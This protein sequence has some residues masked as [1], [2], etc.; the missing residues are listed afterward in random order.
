MINN[1]GLQ[2]SILN[3]FIS[4]IR[5]AEIQKD[6]MRFRRHMERIG[7]IFAYEISKHFNY[8]SREV[9]TSLGVSEVSVLKEQPVIATILR[10]GLPLHQGILNFFDKAQ[11]A[12]VS[13]YRRHH[14]SGKF[15]IQIEYTSSPN[16]DD[17]VLILSDPMLA[18]GSSMLL[19]YKQLLE[20]G[21][22]KHTHI[23]TVIASVQGL[24]YLNKHI[25]REDITVWVAAVDDELTAQS[26]IVPGLGDAGDLAYGSKLNN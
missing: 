5:D 26:Y 20:S 3:E 4:E 19:T 16:I 9:I 22:P 25:S 23:V 14:K 15:D 18:T 10:A 2:N 6:P 1:L 7:E 17:K 24:E 11:N 8:T 21:K 13:A 12:F